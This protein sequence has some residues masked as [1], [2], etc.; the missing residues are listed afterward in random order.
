M[1][2]DKMGAALEFILPRTRLSKI[3]LNNSDLRV[4]AA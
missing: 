2:N 3:C 1:S 4:K